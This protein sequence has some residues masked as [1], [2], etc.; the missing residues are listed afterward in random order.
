MQSGELT[1]TGMDSFHIKLT[2]IPAEIK[3]DFKG[4]EELVP[5]NPHNID[6]LE[7]VVH[8]HKNKFVL[9]IQ[10][11]VIGVREIEWKVTY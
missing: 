7:F 10:W 3:V 5:C 2:G 9:V 11:S 1:V 6:S 4:E 8:H